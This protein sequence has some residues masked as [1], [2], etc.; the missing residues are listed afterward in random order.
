VGSILALPV[1]LF[2][3]FRPDFGAWTHTLKILAY[4]FIILLGVSGALLAILTRTGIVQL[5]YCDAD[6]QSLHYKMSQTVAE[7]ERIQKRGFSDKYYDGL[8]VQPPKQKE[9]DDKPAA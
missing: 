5:I 1:V 7:M 3:F 6:K 4:I 9:S 8:G 2:L